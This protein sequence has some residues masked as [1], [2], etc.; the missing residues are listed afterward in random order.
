MDALLTL[1]TSGLFISLYFLL[2]FKG[3]VSGRLIPKSIC[4]KNYCATLLGTSYARL[5]DVPNFMWGIVYYIGIV[6]WSLGALPVGW[7]PL[8]VTASLAAAG[9]SVYLAYTLIVKLRVVCILCFLSHII[10]IL[11]VMALLR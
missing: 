5:F 3:Y 2:V 10:N 11:I 4:R 7:Y 1:A 6:L 9:F 8:V